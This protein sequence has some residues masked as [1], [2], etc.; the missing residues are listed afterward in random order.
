MGFP[1]KSGSALVRGREG[2]QVTR[3]GRQEALIHPPRSLHQ[4]S[5]T[6]SSEAGRPEACGRLI[7]HSRFLC[8]SAMLISL[9]C[10][11][12][13]ELLLPLPVLYGLLTS[14]ILL[15][16]PRVELSKEA[17][18][19]CHI[20]QES[21]VCREGKD[22]MISAPKK[23]IFGMPLPTL[24]SAVTLSDAAWVCGGCVVL[25]LPS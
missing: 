22:S 12:S 21:V 3:T 9:V 2:E 18:F 15:K 23:Q 17:Y 11:L 14:Q 13:G 24:V 16:G 5:W 20:P 25:L 10:R 1:R 6:P 8:F 19:C 7:S 4:S